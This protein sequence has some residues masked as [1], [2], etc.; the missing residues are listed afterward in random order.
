M[1]EDFSGTGTG[2][3]GPQKESKAKPLAPAAWQVSEEARKNK[4]LQAVL[5]SWEKQTKQERDLRRH[6]AKY[7]LWSLFA[8]AIVV[9]IAFFM[10]G[11]KFIEVEEWTARIF[12]LAVFSELSAMVFFIVK[13]LFA[14]TDE[15]VLR[16]IEKLK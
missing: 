14:P 5:D 2:T 12:I 7:L 16:L 11:W 10:I 3:A 15:N 9:N 6:Y 1:S 4:K 8:Q 13:Y